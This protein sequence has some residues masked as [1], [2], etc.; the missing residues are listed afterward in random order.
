MVLTHNLVNNWRTTAVLQDLWTAF[1]VAV[2]LLFNL[3]SNEMK[4]IGY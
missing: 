1:A 4:Q 2:I 3:L